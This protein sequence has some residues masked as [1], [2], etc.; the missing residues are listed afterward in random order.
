MFS[1]KERWMAEQVAQLLNEKCKVLETLSKCQQEVGIDDSG[2]R[3]G[4]GWKVNWGKTQNI[5]EHRCYLLSFSYAFL[6]YE[7]LESLLRD[8][9]VLA[10]TQRAQDLEVRKFVL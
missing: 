2:R 10:Q 7:D 9:G 8:S 3:D 1:G 5:Y 4:L 6:Q